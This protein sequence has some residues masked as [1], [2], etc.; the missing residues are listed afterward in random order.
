MDFGEDIIENE[1]VQF[2]DIDDQSEGDNN[3]DAGMLS[4]NEEDI[5]EVK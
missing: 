4:Q 1:T 3:S 2:S 5:K